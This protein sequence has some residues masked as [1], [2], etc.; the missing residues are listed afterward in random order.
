MHLIV[1]SQGTESR[2]KV[3]RSSVGMRA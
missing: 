1:G 3:D 2:D